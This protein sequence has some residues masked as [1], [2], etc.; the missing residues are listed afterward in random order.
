MAT[1]REL[2]GPYES[3]LLSPR[4][5]LGVCGVCLNLTDGYTRCYACAH[6]EAWLDVVAPISYS[7]AREP[8]HRALSGYKRASGEPGRRLA[9]GLAAI[10]WRFL[11]EHEP[12]V[13]AAAGAGAFELV[14]TV[15]SA[16]RRRDEQHPLR[17]VVGELVE[18]TRERHERLLRR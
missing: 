2:S 12:C 15:P 6:C 5:G 1:L 13:A 17:R 9:A 11:I 16:D 8:L 10:L 18:P 14:T 7:V 3:F 4:Y